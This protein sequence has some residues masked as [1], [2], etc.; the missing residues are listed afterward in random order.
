MKN[1]ALARYETKTLQI[2]SVWLADIKEIDARPKE[3]SY[4]RQKRIR[5]DR[6][7]YWRLFWFCG[8]RSDRSNSL[9]DIPFELL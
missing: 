9:R 5:L 2:H 4:Q 7:S 6:Y 1:F 8:T 3:R